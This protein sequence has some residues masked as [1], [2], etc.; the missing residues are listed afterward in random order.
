M[1]SF[2]AGVALFAG[3][4]L[5]ATALAIAAWLPSTTTG[6]SS[7]EPV[8]RLAERVLSPIGG[9]GTKLIPAAVSPGLPIWIPAEARVIGT[10]IR[11][12]PAG[13]LDGPATEVLLD[14]PGPAETVLRSLTASL[15]ADGL[16]RMSSGHPHGELPRPDEPLFATFCNETTWVT[17][18]ISAGTQ[19][20][21]DVRLAVLPTS[22]KCVPVGVGRGQ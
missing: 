17:L 22:E 18:G 2:L 20:M 12:G 19:G 21:R 5:L 9:S 6:V 13:K 7:T 8:R 1:W 16:K 10:V 14:I 15:E 11:P 4:V 3:G